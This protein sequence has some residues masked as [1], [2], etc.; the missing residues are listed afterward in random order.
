MLI[1]RPIIIKISEAKNY[2]DKSAFQK[3]VKCPG[4]SS[5]I[6]RDP[7]VVDNNVV[8][9]NNKCE[10]EF[11]W[12]CLKETLRGEDDINHFDDRNYLECSGRQFYD[13]RQES[14]LSVCCERL[15][16]LLC[17]PWI[18]IYET[19]KSSI[20]AIHKQTS[21]YLSGVNKYLKWFLLIL[22]VYIYLIPI[23]F[24][25]SG[26]IVGTLYGVL[27]CL[28]QIGIT[29]KICCRNISCCGSRKH[30]ESTSDNRNDIL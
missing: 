27:S 23:T 19:T 13:V 10:K 16:M 9:P 21:F 22:F 17:I 30:L 7:S 6:L 28:S 24:I 3:P 8:C 5:L 20:Q 18:N 11:C 1:R 15:R 14:K 25:F 12:I 4:C 2:K 26:L 29:F